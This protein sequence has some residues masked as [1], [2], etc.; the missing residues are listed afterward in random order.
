MH[1]H[2]STLN[3]SNPNNP[4]LSLLGLLYQMVSFKS[5]ADRAPI[6]EDEATEG[7]D[8]AEGLGPAPLNRKNGQLSPCKNTH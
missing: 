7:E 8:V 5:R 3:Y 2:A 6:G 1:T 4:L